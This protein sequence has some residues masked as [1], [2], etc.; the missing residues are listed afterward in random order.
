MKKFDPNAELSKVQKKKNVSVN[1]S[2]ISNMYIPF[3]VV[4]C[5]CL[6]MIGI[7]FSS[8]LSL[9]EEDVYNVKIDIINGEEEKI[10]TRVAEGAYSQTIKGNGTFGSISCSSGSLDYDPITSSVYSPFVNQNTSCVIAF[11]D[12]GIKYI[13]A[14]NLNKINDNYGV[15]YYYK[16][17]AL[18]NYLKFD[19]KMF[20]I[21]RING[22]G[23]IRIMLD[24]VILASDYGSLNEYYDSN[25]KKTL[26]NW[27]D[28]NV[29]K[30]AKEYVVLGDYD[31]NNYVNY[32]IYNLI[33]YMDYELDYVGTLSVRE[34]E[35]M[36]S[37]VKI[38]NDFLDTISG[39]YLSN[40][41]GEDKVFYYDNGNVG[42]ISSDNKLSVRP[43]INI[44]KV[45]LTGDG[46]A[47]SPYVISE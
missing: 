45:T 25:V 3:L 11:M 5:S 7:T 39:M 30:K 33:N 8:K 18:N 27:Y 42:S 21:I 23:S 40:G 47:N 14:D 36:S 29:S 43:V 1:A 9:D 34:A 32:D 24:S 6:A 35:L 15:S 2:K 28:N 41:N 46:T 4:G 38:T 26:Y 31:T 20:R 17:N 12:D 10:E 13:D 22:D 19:D 37:D 16:V 44:K